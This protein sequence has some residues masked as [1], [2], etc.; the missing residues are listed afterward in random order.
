M[1]S[2]IVYSDEFVKIYTLSDGLYLE[3]IKSGMPFNQLNGIINSHPEFR[4]VNFNV[5]KDAIN[6]APQP[7]KKFGELKERIVIKISQDALNATITYNAPKEYVDPKNR[8]NL[9]KE[10]YD[11]LSKNSITFGIN[12]EL[13]SGEI[14]AGKTY[15]IAEGQASVDGEDSIIK[16]Y[17]LGELKPEIKDDGKTNYYELKL[18]NKVK[19]GDWLGE[20]IEAKE[21]IPGRT[22]TGDTIKA[23]KGKQFPLLYDK[24]T[25]Y[26]ILSNNKTVLYSKINGAV[27]YIDGKI[28]VSNHL[29]IDGDVDFNT[30]NIHFDG[31]VTINGT[32]TDGFSVEATKDI[33]INGTLGLGNV[34]EIKSLEGSI[35]IK[36]GIVSKTQSV[37]YA[38]KDIYTKFSDNVTLECGGLANIGFYCINST[39]NAKEVFIESS[40]GNIIG[41]HIKA[42]TKVT[43]AV[44]GSTLEAKTLVE[45]TGFN[46]ETYKDRLNTVIQNIKNLKDKQQSLK[47]ELHGV[48][49]EDMTAQEIKQYN[50]NFL[51]SVEIRET[52]K[53]LE[54]ERKNITRHLRTK[55]EGEISITKKVYPNCTFIIKDKQKDII[56]SNISTS[57]FY[58]DNELKQT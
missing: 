4:I 26:E 58:V 28:T 18:I 23:V 10:T 19:A 38:K 49:Q 42:E 56:H 40:K 17:E 53:T 54:Y 48:S 57:F 22:V 20:R 13:L 52:I 15:T 36:G 24:N 30:G 33:E 34:K 8:E 7:P 14:K 37:I 41:G 6:S 55:G 1:N 29:E 50:E 12:R 39:V 27:D 25:V 2:E 47:S 51:K 44:I 5:I 31:Y 45:V 35:F 46:R 43:S 16:M 21:G 3:S 32:V 11:A 9:I